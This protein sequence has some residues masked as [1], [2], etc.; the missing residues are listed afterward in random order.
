[1]NYNDPVEVTEIFRVITIPAP[2]EE[3]PKPETTTKEYAH[4]LSF[5]WE[6]VKSIREYCYADDWTH[7]KGP[8]FHLRV[9]SNS[10]ESLILGDYHAF[11]SHW[12][13]FRNNYPLFVEHTT[14]T[15]HG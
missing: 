12:R 5:G 10:E 6:G 1:M 4:K 8:K 14:N 13:N 15:A 3:E 9:D 2:T 11:Y 7:Y